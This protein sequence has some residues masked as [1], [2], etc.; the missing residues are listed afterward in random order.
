MDFEL[1]GKSI[2]TLDE[3]HRQIGDR[4]DLGPFYG[5]NF[6]ALRD[7]LS[8]D[9]ERPLHLIWRDSAVSRAHLGAEAFDMAVDVL[10]ATQNEDARMNRDERFTFTLA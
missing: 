2:R 3:F 5:R 1:D 8:T 6:N 9:V 10:R 7:L 4:L